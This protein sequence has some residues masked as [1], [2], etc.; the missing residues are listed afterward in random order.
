MAIIK[1]PRPATRAFLFFKRLI[2]F[3]LSPEDGGLSD[4]V[5]ISPGGGGVGGAGVLGAGGGVK[6][7]GGGEDAGGFSAGKEAGCSTGS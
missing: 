7:C 4:E 6:G 2:P 3:F 1:A 5:I